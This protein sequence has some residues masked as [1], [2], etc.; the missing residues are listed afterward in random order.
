M[1]ELLDNAYKNYSKKHFNEWKPGME[2][3]SK[4][5]FINKIKTDPEFAKEW[6]VEVSVRELSLEERNNYY[7]SH[8]LG[9]DETKEELDKM[10]IPTRAITI[11]YNNEIIE[12]YE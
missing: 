7:T 11:T 1:Y 4:E 8:Y 9:L 3:E 2:F 12:I 10:N 5:S 6:N